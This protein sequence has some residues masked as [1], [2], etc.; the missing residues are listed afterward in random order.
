MQT[1]VMPANRALVDQLSHQGSLLD[2]PKPGADF[3]Q[4]LLD[5]IMIYSG[6]HTLHNE[7]RQI[8]IPGENN[9]MF[10]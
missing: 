6:M 3:R 7:C 5:A 1:L 9:R 4:G 2:D 10:C 8:V